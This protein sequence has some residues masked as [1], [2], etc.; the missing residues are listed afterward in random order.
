M[1]AWRQTWRKGF[2][3]LLTT[4]QL[5]ALRHGLQRD[6]GKLIQGATTMPPPMQCVL[7]W[8]CDGACAITYAAWKADDVE[9]VGELEVF[10]AQICFDA[11][12]RIEEPAACR[13]FLNWFD[14]TPRDEMRRLLIPE[15]DRE[16]AEREPAPEPVHAYREAVP[17]DYLTGRTHAEQQEALARDSQ[18]RQARP[19]PFNG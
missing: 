18:Y 2:A 13:Y 17:E 16:L 8:P 12:Q 5:E 1:E 15:I 19:I 4:A 11:D 3:P 7:D 9:T 6:D 10:F 14:D